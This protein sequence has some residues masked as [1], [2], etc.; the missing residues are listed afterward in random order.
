MGHVTYFMQF[1]DPLQADWSLGVLTKNAKLDQHG[2][3][4]GH[5]TYFF[6][7]GTL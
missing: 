3:E 6:K 2:P 5:V 7:F 4:Q 1:W